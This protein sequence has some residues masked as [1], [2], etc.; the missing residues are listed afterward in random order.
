M[1][2]LNANKQLEDETKE[3]NI[4]QGILSNMMPDSIQGKRKFLENSYN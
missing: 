3:K 1:E 2:L 4:I